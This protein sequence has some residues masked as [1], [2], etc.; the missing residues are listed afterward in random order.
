MD[1][2]FIIIGVVILLLIVIGTIFFM[3]T[4]SPTPN[5][6]T[7]SIDTLAQAAA[8]S[9]PIPEEEAEALLDTALANI[10]PENKPAV[11]AVTELAKAATS[12]E[13]A[14][15]PA[16]VEAATTAV[17]AVQDS[18][19]YEKYENQ[20]FFGNDIIGY[21]GKTINQCMD[22]CNKLINCKAITFD[23][24]ATGPRCWL[25]S[26]ATFPTRQRTDR[27]SYMKK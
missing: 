11:E 19:S 21:S 10:P 25:K 23:K 2:K 16:V 4:S 15:V 7:D 6:S 9:T 24:T 1:K 22:E 14:A 18:I 12:P 20:D 27:D 3:N 17:A 13:P 26:V 5:E 8:S